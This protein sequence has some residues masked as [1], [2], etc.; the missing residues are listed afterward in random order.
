SNFKNWDPNFDSLEQDLFD[1]LE[2]IKNDRSNED[3]IYEL[4]IKYGL[5]LNVPIETNVISGKEIY[6]IG[7][8]AL[9]VCLDKDLSLEIVNAIGKLKENL[10]PEIMRVVFKDDG[11]KDDV[12]KTNALQALKLL[13][14]QD[15]KSI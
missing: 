10:K 3:I 6:S 1:A 11:F 2:N 9:I 7:L 8:G 12:I 13:G 4:L 15:I 5:D 14:I